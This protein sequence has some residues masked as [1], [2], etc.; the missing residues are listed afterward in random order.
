[1]SYWKRLF[2]NPDV[3]GAVLFGKRDANS[4]RVYPITIDGSTGALS[5]IDYAHHEIHGGSSYGVSDTVAC[6]TS[7]CKWMITTPDSMKYMHL[8]FELSCT[9][10]ATF[11][12]TEGADRT[13]GTILLNVNRRRVGTSNVSEAVVSRTPT[14]G[15]IDGAITLFSIRDGITNIAAKNIIP[16]SGR[17][18]NEWILKPNT[19]YIISITTYAD[20]F[21]TCRLDWYE[22]TDRES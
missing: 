3:A 5:T 13:A 14:A 8:I 4:E 2:G 20:T 1:M 7:T 10:E 6:N 22:H 12:V 21:V 11:L 9:G 15:T 17:E 18:I 19:K 16:G